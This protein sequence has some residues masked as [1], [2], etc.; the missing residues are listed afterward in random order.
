LEYQRDARVRP[1]ATPEKEFPVPAYEHRREV[2]TE[3]P[4]VVHHD[5]HEPAQPVYQAP[6]PSIVVD[7]SNSLT[8]YAVIKYS[9]I[10]VMTIIIL[11]FVA[12][13]VLPLLTD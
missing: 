4:A 9:F 3:Q 8:A 6:P 2:Y 5:H 10:L 13:F 12:R 1:P 11:Y 7:R